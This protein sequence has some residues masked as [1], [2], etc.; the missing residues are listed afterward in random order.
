[1]AKVDEAPK[2]RF[3]LYRMNEDLTGSLTAEGTKK[4]LDFDLNKDLPRI[5]AIWKELDE[6]EKHTVCYGHR[7]TIFDAG[8]SEK[9]PETKIAASAKRHKSLYEERILR[10]RSAA[11]PGVKISALEQAA[12]DAGVPIELFQAMMAKLTSAKK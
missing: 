3:N 5:A 10:T 7:Q 12:K 9:T 1:M 8:A 11:D 2:K 4:R 6:V